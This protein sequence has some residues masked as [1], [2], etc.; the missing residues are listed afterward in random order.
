MRFLETLGPRRQSPAF[1]LRGIR[2]GREGGLGLRGLVARARR[3]RGAPVLRDLVARARRIRG[4][5]VLR[6][7]QQA[8]NKAANGFFSYSSKCHQG[9][10]KQER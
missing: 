3:N 9:K 5:P 4:A 7:P 6:E 8:E 1:T 10:E 2:F